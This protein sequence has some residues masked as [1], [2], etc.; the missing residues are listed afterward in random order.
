[1]S[2]ILSRRELDSVLVLFCDA[3]HT[4]RSIVPPLLLQQKALV[5][6]IIGPSLPSL[7]HEASILRQGLNARFGGSATR[8]FPDVVDQARQFSGALLNQ[9]QLL[10]WRHRQM[11]SPV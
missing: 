8:T 1:M 11:R 7:A 6:Q 4:G 10:S 9:L 3:A 2:R 5:N